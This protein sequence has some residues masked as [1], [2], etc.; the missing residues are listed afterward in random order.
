MIFV[1]NLLAKAKKLAAAGLS[2]AVLFC[3]GACMGEEGK[4]PSG[5]SGSSIA[6]MTPG[7]PD[8]DTASLPNVPASDKF[9]DFDTTISYDRATAVTVSLQDGGSSANGAGVAVD[10]D[11]VFIQAGGTYILSGT[12]SNGQIVVEV[13][14]T[15]KVQLVLENVSVTSSFSAALYVKSA[16]KVALTLAGGSVNFFSDAASYTEQD[17]KGNPNAC[18]FS[19]DDL[20]VNG[21]GALKVT[22]NFNN[23]ISTTNDLKIVSGTVEV[24]AKNN[25]I[26]GKES[27]LING[28]TVTVNSED[29]GIKV[30]ETE[31]P[32]K[33]FLIIEGG[34]I[35]VTA[36][37]DALQAVTGITVSGGKV[38]TYAGGKSVNCDTNVVIAD[39]CLVEK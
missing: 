5:G 34:D 19:K 36:A 29:D 7:T 33:G 39:G 21:Y 37:D 26:R 12:L 17:E 24:S 35:T 30:S 3:C 15:E 32:A 23:G 27:V 14:K 11:R 10:G 2:L 38:T 20:T 25:A 4:T 9:S 18:I 1:V 22:G 6:D 16:D 31:D 8:S 13:E 28:G